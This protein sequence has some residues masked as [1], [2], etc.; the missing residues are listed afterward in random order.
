MKSFFALILKTLW[1]KMISTRFV[2]NLQMCIKIFK[3]PLPATILTKV[4]TDFRQ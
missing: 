2:E 3:Q 1:T 4:A